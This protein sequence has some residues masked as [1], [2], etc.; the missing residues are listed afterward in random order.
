MRVGVVG[1]WLVCLGA[2]MAVAETITLD[3]LRSAPAMVELGDGNPSPATV[4]LERTWTGSL[5]NATVKNTGA[6][7]VALGRVV[8]FRVAHRLPADTAL[9]GEG[10]TMLSQ[11]GGT[12]GN[13][14][15]IGDYTDARHY[16]IPQPADATTVYELMHL[17]PPGENPLLFA[18][19][20]CRRFVGRFHLRAD[21]IEV[22]LDTEGQVLAPGE[23]WQLEQFTF[24]DGAD[25]NASLD[26]VSAGVQANHPRLTF[27]PIPTGWCSWYCFG[28]M[29]S[30]TMIEANLKAVKDLGLPLDYIQIDDGYQAAMGDWL[31][32]GKAFGG[33]VRDV[34]K[35]IADAGNTPAIWVAPFVAQEDSKVFKEHPEWF[36]KDD[37]GAPLRSDRVTFGGWRLGPWYALDGTHPEA[38]KHLE[39]VFRTMRKEWGCRYFKLDANFWGAIHCGHFHDPKATRV[40]A[41]RRGMEAVLRGAGDSFILGCNHPLWP[42]LGVIHGARSSGDVS[43]SWANFKHLAR[44]NF[45]RNWQNGK[46]WW[47]D[48]DCVLLT[49]TLSADEF[50]FHASVIYACGGMTLSGDNLLAM[51]PERTAMLK[52]LLPPTGVA[53]R[54]TDARF[55]TGWIPLA[56]KSQLC[57]FNWDDTAKTIGVDLPGKVTLRDF[58]NDAD[59]G[60]ASGRFE[61]KE[62]PPHSARIIT[63]TPAP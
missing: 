52:K 7:P 54:F 10:F 19:T 42:S 38:Q 25:L 1:F 29:I 32:T 55:E 28:P 8:L 50:Q 3:A 47:N 44:E 16:K 17:T 6:A 12:L 40:E 23:A 56:D 30:K 2:Q 37:A 46:F 26:Y 24:L 59:L 22:V 18:F 57:L 4:V 31:D 60:T 51:S 9:Y 14:V 53:A 13:P 41:Y 34:L 27:S 45:S 49:G 33:G 43:R 36:V 15:D 11:T 21:S 62:M 61:I 48:P 39:T 20:S 35:T 5:C 58:W 63:C